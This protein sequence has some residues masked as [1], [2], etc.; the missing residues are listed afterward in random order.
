M[1]IHKL[2]RS[3]I[4]VVGS[5][6][7]SS[8]IFGL[9]FIFWSILQTFYSFLQKRLTQ[10]KLGRL[11]L[12]IYGSTHENHDIGIMGSMFKEIA[13]AFQQLEVHGVPYSVRRT[14]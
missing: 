13:D 3:L 1:E 10:A 8:I 14:P 6:F 5:I 7:S 4:P 12:D 2:L 9:D 11:H